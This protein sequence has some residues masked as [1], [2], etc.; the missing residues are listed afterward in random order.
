MSPIRAGLLA[1]CLLVTVCPPAVAEPG[2]S[3]D[4]V[5]DARREVRSRTRDL[6]AVNARLAAAR[7]RLD[8]LATTAGRLVEAYNGEKVRLARAEQAHRDA[9]TRLSA[10]ETAMEAARVEAAR[11]AGELYGGA[12]V[13]RP[14]VGMINTDGYLHRVS[15]LQQI[16]GERGMVLVR[17]R[18]SRLVAQV[19]REEAERARREQQAAAERAAAA[20]QAAER[21]VAEQLKETAA[22]KEEREE[23]ES[24]LDAARSEA[25][26]LER[27]RAETLE[28]SSFGYVSLASGSARGDLAANWALSQLGKP[29]V[30]AADGPSSYDCSGLTMRAWER[31]GV[32]LDHWTGT[33]WTSG[34]HVPLNQLRR[35]DLLFFGYVSR[36]PGTIHHVGMYIGKGLMVHAPQTGD[37]V[38]VASMWRRDLVGATRPAG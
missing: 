37:V 35:G 27:R 2:P 6:G 22:L 26:R 5:A 10:A 28:R 11:L 9:L 32:R 21:A 24:E 16:G 15:V 7:A 36:D 17:M 12:D 3:A 38:R 14:F 23:L 1:A 4:D 18:D 33:Q 30:W 25:E 29:Y 13:N 20:Q 31:V 34:P 19:L 8:A